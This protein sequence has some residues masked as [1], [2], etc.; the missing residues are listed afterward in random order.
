MADS[1]ALNSFKE[2]I[3]EIWESRTGSDTGFD[4]AWT[5]LQ[6]EDNKDEGL[7]FYEE[8]KFFNNLLAEANEPESTNGYVF[9]KPPA[10]DFGTGKNNLDTLYTDAKTEVDEIGRQKKEYYESGKLIATATA[11]ESGLGGSIKTPIY[12]EKGNEIGNTNAVYGE[13]GNLKYFRETEISKET[14]D[15]GNT[16]TTEKTITH[17]ANGETTESNKVNTFDENNNPIKSVS[18]LSDDHIITTE[19]T[20]DNDGNITGLVKTEQDGDITI[21]STHDADDLSEDGKSFKK[22]TLVFYKNGEIV[23]EYE[24]EF[25]Y[26]NNGN[27][28]GFTKTVTNP[29]GTVTT[30]QETPESIGRQTY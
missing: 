2:L 3:E 21:V 25:R 28:I 23:D 6:T 27:R 26:D 18:V 1:L 15:A 13:D 24:L 29:D 16:V 12:D 7:N 20:F 8:L 14:D 5:Q 30:T 4:E 17:T 9:D 19:N 22:G 11:F 10:D